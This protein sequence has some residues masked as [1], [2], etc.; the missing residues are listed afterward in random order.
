MRSGS[1]G[2]PRRPYNGNRPF[3]PQQ[4]APQ[5]NQ[6]FDSSGPGGRIR[7]NAR[8]IFERY[9]ALARESAIGGDPVA[10]EN[11]YQHAEHY[12][13]LSNANHEGNQSERSPRPSMP[14]DVVMDEPQP[15]ASDTDTD[16]AHPSWE[17]DQSS[18]N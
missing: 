2:R 15:E 7:G 13:R 9:V 8:Q 1:D 3:R 16:R 14:D 17:N 4:R 6:A 11:L 10:A 5:H 18:F 12:F